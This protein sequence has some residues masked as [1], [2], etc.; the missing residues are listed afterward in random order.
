MLKL[1]IGLILLLLALGTIK[2]EERP[3]VDVAIIFATD[4]SGSINEDRFKLQVEGL[5]Q[6]IEDP[7]II[8]AMTRGYNK[9][10]ALAYVQWSD[11]LEQK[12]TG[13][14]IIRS[15]ED[16]KKFANM[17]RSEPR[18]FSGGTNIEGAM[19]FSEYMF[20][21]AQ[22]EPERK[23]IDIS[24]DGKGGNVENML[25]I[26]ERLRRQGFQINGLAILNDEPDILEWYNNHV[27]TGPG[28]FTIL[29]RDFGDFAPA[30]RR[31]IITELVQN[32][33]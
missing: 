3:T 28:S 14:F 11:L 19:R 27:R 7:D 21:I 16:A 8:A 15:A 2:A 10:V 33:D 32:N 6:A 18:A 4:V 25:L 22:F 29:A 5:A 20:S 17:I 31:K 9:Q 1:F 24:G 12:T 13:W 26:R 23:V 30:I